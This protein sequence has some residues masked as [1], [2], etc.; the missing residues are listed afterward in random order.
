MNAHLVHQLYRRGWLE[1]SATACEW[2]NLLPDP[3][4]DP[5]RIE[6][7]VRRH[8]DAPTVLVHVSRQIGGE[9]E[10][11]EA[12]RLICPYIGRYEILIAS[13]DFSSRVAIG[14]PGVGAGFKGR[15]RDG[16]KYA[17]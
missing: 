17:G 2:E 4:P 15:P 5:A 7:F 14:I 10:V 8:I 11:G 16:V 3:Q 13:Q 9:L 1:Y 12:V 6:R